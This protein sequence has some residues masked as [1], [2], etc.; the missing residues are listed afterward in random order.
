MQWAGKSPVHRPIQNLSSKKHSPENL[1]VQLEEHLVRVQPQQDTMLSVGVFDGVHIGHQKLLAR[2]RDEAQ[3]RNMMSGV[4]TFKSHP[5]VVL[6]ESK[7]LWLS[8]LETRIDL[9]R[10]LG[11]DIVIALPFSPELARL[12][13][14]QFVQLLI[15]HLRM[16]GLIIGPDFALGKNREG[17]VSRLQVLGEEMGFSVEAIPVVII[18][19]LVVSSST[20]RQA[21]AEGDMKIVEKLI[22]RLFSLSGRVVSGDRR[23]RTLGFPTANLDI[24]PEQALPADGVYATITHTDQND[25]P[26]VTNIGVRPTFGGTKRLVETYILDFSGDLLGQ[27]LIVDL[28]ERLREEERF[29][30]TAALKARM[31]KDVEQARLILDERLKQ[32]KI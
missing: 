7:V 21:L 29:D 20:I 5:E 8:D 3:S 18:D 12:T 24:K 30:T 15:K 19:G 28:V 23:G 27:N 4:V 14:Q 1:S 6:G 32:T 17:D 16:R 10:N 2:L 26:S 22:G 31:I 9:I 13:A 25:L 11:I